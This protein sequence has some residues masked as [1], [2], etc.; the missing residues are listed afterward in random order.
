MEHA[1]PAKRRLQRL[2][3]GT[4]AGPELPRTPGRLGQATYSARELCQT[5]LA[6]T[7][8]GLPPASQAAATAAVTQ[9]ASGAAAALQAAA[10]PAPLSKSPFRPDQIDIEVWYQLRVHYLDEGFGALGADGFQAF[11]AAVATMAP[12]A[13]AAATYPRGL[14]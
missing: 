4:S 5:R 7:I 13:P 8:G 1:V 6:V 2:S 3:C 12:L 9:H 11:G 14:K 10:P